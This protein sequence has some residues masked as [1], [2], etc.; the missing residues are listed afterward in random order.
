MGKEKGCP[1]CVMHVAEKVLPV[2]EPRFCLSK[3]VENNVYNGPDGLSYAYACTM[4]Q[5]PIL[6]CYIVISCK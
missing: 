4:G 1:S 3:E 5:F 2:V 6:N